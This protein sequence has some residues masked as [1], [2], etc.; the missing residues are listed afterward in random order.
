MKISLIILIFIPILTHSQTKDIIWGPI[1]K[2]SSSASYSTLV[3]TEDLIYELKKTQ[4]TSY[5]K[6]IDQKNMIALDSAKLELKWESETHEIIR[7]FMFLDKPHVLTKTFDQYKGITSTWVHILN[8]EELKLSDPFKI[9]DYNTPAVKKTG[10][11]PNEEA[12]RIFSYNLIRIHTSLLGEHC[13]AISSKDLVGNVV[14]NDKDKQQ[15]RILE[16]HFFTESFQKRKLNYFTPPSN[17]FYF[18]QI[19]LDLDGSV[20][21]LGRTWE[22]DFSRTMTAR[23]QNIY[24]INNL[25]IIKYNPVSGDYM[26]E[27]I[28]LEGDYLQDVRMIVDGDI[29]VSGIAEDKNNS[30][31][32]F[33]AQYT[34]DL[35]RKTFVKEELSQEFVSQLNLKHEVDLAKKNYKKS[36]G[37]EPKNLPLL[38]F[39]PILFEKMNNGDIIFGIEKKSYILSGTDYYYLYG[40]IVLFCY[41]G[42]IKKWVKII[43]KDQKVSSAKYAGA[44]TFIDGENL[45]VLFNEGDYKIE[46]EEGYKAVDLTVQASKPKRIRHYI[47]NDSGEITQNSEFNLSDKK[48]LFLEPS[49]CGEVAP[50]SLVFQATNKT[51]KVLGIFK[52]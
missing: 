15:D 14:E 6:K 47:F 31:N 17:D 48:P 41:N 29:H 27:K 10:I 39:Q 40:D 34:P 1:Q 12:T 30:S 16:T 22:V 35:I 43:E 8:E 20:Y 24:G 4:S 50:G 52:Y 13:I 51:Q 44:V 9:A 49:I 5:L 11:N 42:N 28:E 21:M 38:N 45:H 46:M 19:A 33:Y 3:A 25:Q 37:I 2:Y 26:T 32:Y 18:Y 36:Y 23:N 7:G